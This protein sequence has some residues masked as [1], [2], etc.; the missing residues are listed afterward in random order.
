MNANETEWPTVTRWLVNG[1][2][3]TDLAEAEEF[4]DQLEQAGEDIHFQQVQEPL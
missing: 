3:F 2:S 1:E 4:A